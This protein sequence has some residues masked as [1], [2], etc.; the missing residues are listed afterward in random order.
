MPRVKQGKAVSVRG[1]IRNETKWDRNLLLAKSK[2]REESAQLLA[3]DKLTDEQIAA[4]VGM[5]RATLARWKNLPEFTA[6]VQEITAAYAERALN[7]GMARK[8]RRLHALNDLFGRLW[9]I[10][11]ERA[12]DPMME[13]VPGGST[14]LLTRKVKSVGRGEN[15]KEV[16]LYVFDAALL[17]ELCAVMAQAADELGTKIGGAAE[18]IPPS[19]GSLNATRVNVNIIPG[20]SQTESQAAKNRRFVA[21]MRECY[22][23][24][25]QF[26]T[27]RLTVTKPALTSGSPTT[28]ADQERNGLLP[29]PDAANCLCYVIAAEIWQR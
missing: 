26:S 1:I 9:R 2:K 19:Q 17:R 27:E 3:E 15:L 14:G 25:E 5:G 4:K 20:E 13:K 8:E 12:A 28:G 10:V 29:V 21:V 16:E 6:R 7:F 24:P 18:L 22:G 11:E 23:L